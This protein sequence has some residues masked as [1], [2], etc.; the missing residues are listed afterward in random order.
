MTD[1]AIIDIA[2]ILVAHH[3]ILNKEKSFDIEKILLPLIKGWSE[4]GDNGPTITVVSDLKGIS[5]K[6]ESLS[7][8]VENFVTWS[9]V[10]N[11]SDLKAVLEF[12]ESILRE[13]FYKDEV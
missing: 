10:P 9:E 8:T 5:F 4:F 11:G 13:Y 2:K 1:K 3:F 6:S 12:I 7:S